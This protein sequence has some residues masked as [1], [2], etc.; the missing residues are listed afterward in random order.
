MKVYAN[1][2]FNNQFDRFIG[3]DLWVRVAN[4]AGDMYY[5]RLYRKLDMSTC[6]ASCLSAAVIDEDVSNLTF[7]QVI[8]GARGASGEFYWTSVNLNDLQLVTPVEVLTS[9]ELQEI[10]KQKIPEELY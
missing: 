2:K 5:L 8:E 7:E 10:L 3:K 1:T 9:G 6:T 4:D